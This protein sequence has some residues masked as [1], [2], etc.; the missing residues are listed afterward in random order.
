MSVLFYHNEIPRFVLDICETPPMQRLKAVGMNCGCEYTSFP[1]LRKTDAYSRFEHS[2]GAGLIVWHF[3]QNKVQTTAALLHDISTPVFAHTIDFLNGDFLKQESTEAKTE[4]FIR[5]SDGLCRVLEK[6]NI[7]L[8][9]VTDYHRYPIADNDSPQLSSDR[10]EYTLGNAVRYGIC[11]KREAEKLYGDI[12]VG[13]NEKSLEELVFTTE[14][15][16]VRFAEIALE[17][18]KIY[19]SEEDR[20]SMKI[21]SE[22]M[23]RAIEKKV[24]SDM[25]LYS[26][27]KNVISCMES[28][29]ELRTRWNN[30]RA[31][32][33]MVHDEKIPEE[34]RR[35]ILAKKRYIDPYAAGRGRATQISEAFAESLENYLNEPQTKWLYGE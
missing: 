33:K 20:Y 11:D 16:A 15:N 18:S 3:T 17:C 5:N 2:L 34:S 10:L 28:D 6:N 31:L 25:D 35:V 24:I 9:D 4:S 21:L 7:P 27:E 13:L 8:D 19:V 30:F 22:I 32:H 23:A 29:E 14:K 12:C 26:D 1:V